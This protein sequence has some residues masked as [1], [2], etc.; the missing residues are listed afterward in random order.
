VEANWEDRRSPWH[1]GEYLKKDASRLREIPHVFVVAPIRYTARKLKASSKRS[2]AEPARDLQM[3]CVDQNYWE[4][5][6]P[7]RDAGRLIS[8][9]DVN[10]RAPVCVLHKELVPEL[11]GKENP[12]GRV[13]Y[14]TS[15]EYRVIGTLTGPAN[16]EICR[17]IFIPISLADR[18]LGQARQFTRMQIR[19]DNPDNV[20]EVRTQVE[21]TLKKA[22]PGYEKAVWVRYHASRLERVNMIMS[23]VTMFGYAAL[24]A[25][26]ILG[27]VGLTNV[28]LSAVQ[29]RTREVGLRKALGA[30][31][32][33]IRL[34]FVFESVLV[35]LI[36][37]TIGAFLGIITSLAAKELLAFEI[38]N[39]VLSVSVLI[40]LCITTAVGMVAGSYPSLV[41]SRL[42]IV[43]AM[44]FD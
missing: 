37:G 44:R 35:C 24:A 1:L 20:K 43:T 19:V 12:I 26:F 28:M 30:T 8:A 38:S 13:I 7:Y 14:V 10:G 36:A 40:D 42:D 17:S 29:E 11:F 25:V 33:M 16:T 23:L 39:Y 5:I 9:S 21:M 27:K 15:Y 31:D 41:A 34:Q 6:S 32:S 18:H 4:T 2:D 3:T 22:H